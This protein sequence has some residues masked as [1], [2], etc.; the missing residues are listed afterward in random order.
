[1]VDRLFIAAAV[2]I[3]A[4]QLGQRLGALGVLVRDREEAHGWVLGGE[5]RPQ[6]ADPA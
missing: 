2:E 3:G 6:R 4:R 5:P 1:M